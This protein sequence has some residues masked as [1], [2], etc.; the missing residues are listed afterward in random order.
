MDG[1]GR[2]H[3]GECKFVF[4]RQGDA[5]DFGNA[6]PLVTGGIW[7]SN[8]AT[9]ARKKETEENRRRRERGRATIPEVFHFRNALCNACREIFP[10][11]Q[12]VFPT[13]ASACE[14]RVT[15]L[16]LLRID[17]RITN[18]RCT[19]TV[20]LCQSMCTRVKCACVQSFVGVFRP[21]PPPPS[22][23]PLP[24]PPLFFSPQIRKYRM[25]ACYFV[26]LLLKFLFARMQ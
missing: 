3:C 22:P 4:V 21:P 12:N 15:K 2:R 16:T 19:R 11:S 18:A 24:P 14:E 7:S 17:G 6:I 26:M 9:L 8:I 1:M 5:R 23:Q 25:L 10:S 20:E 13:Q